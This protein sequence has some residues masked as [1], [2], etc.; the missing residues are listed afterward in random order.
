MVTKL[1][2]AEAFADTLARTKQISGKGISLP[3]Y[4][5]TIR[6]GGGASTLVKTL[7]QFLYTQKVVPFCGSVHSFE[8]SLHYAM[9]GTFFTEQFRLESILSDMAGHRNTFK[10]VVC[11]HINEWTGY[12]DEDYFQEFLEY[13]RSK[14]KDLVLVFC[15]QQSCPIMEAALANHMRIETVEICF[16]DAEE[17][18]CWMEREYFKPA[19]VTFT[20]GAKLLLMDTIKEL[21]ADASFKSMQLLAE[22]ILYH[23]LSSEQESKRISAHMLAPYKLGGVYIAGRKV[24]K[25]KTQAIGF[26]RKENELQL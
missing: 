6:K 22:D 14:Q 1:L 16:P 9:P 4:L 19:G 24:K 10:G 2:G 25:E 18:F 12:T 7:T 21:A 5:W 8:F 17:L 3:S 13:I 23:V 15:V 26:H 20:R 11:I